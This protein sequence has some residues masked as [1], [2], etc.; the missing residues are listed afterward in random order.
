MVGAGP[1]LDRNIRDLQ[2]MDGRVLLIAVDTAL[3]P[4]LAAGI[5]PQ[6]V[7]SVDP[8]E[9]NARHLRDIADRRGSWLVA[10]AS[11]DPAV[12]PPYAGRTFTFNVSQHQPWPWLSAHGLGRGT[13]RAWGS[14]LTTAFDLAI[15]AGCDPI[16]FAGADLAYSGGLQYCRN[17]TYEDK[18]RD[19]PTDAARAALFKTYLAERPHLTQPDVHG[20][21]VTTTPHFVQ[22]RDWIVSRANE[23][24]DRRIVNA[25]GG[26]ILQGGRIAQTD[27]SVL[28]LPKAK[29]DLGLHR[30][31]HAAWAAGLDQRLEQ[32]HAL[33]HR[34]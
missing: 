5:V 15:R 17:T 7:V 6:I 32:H 3:R 34:Q 21:A 9:L 19:F 29:H 31:L 14:V 25:T 26:G 24:A 20:G 2:K 1:S 23:A 12:F 4:L 10:E 27:F 22:F 33:I 30:R 28:H 18:W 11:I 13:L 16:V 8:S